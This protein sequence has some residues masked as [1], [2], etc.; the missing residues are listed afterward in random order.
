VACAPADERILRLKEITAADHALPA[1]LLRNAKTVVVWFIPFK[2]HIQMD[3]TEGKRPS[4]S[5][6]RAYLSTTD[7]IDCIG[8]AMKNFVEKEDG[9]AALNSATHNFDKKRMGGLWSHHHLGHSSG[10]GRYGTNG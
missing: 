5:W 2:H 8:S 3:N 7:K 9:E 10:L 4:L 1:D 6:G